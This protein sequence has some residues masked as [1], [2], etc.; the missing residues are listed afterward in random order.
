MTKDTAPKENDEPKFV[1][2]RL[3]IPADVLDGA[4]KI[5][6]EYGVTIPEAVR[7]MLIKTMEDKAPPFD[8]RATLKEVYGDRIPNRETFESFDAIER[9]E[10]FHAKDFEDLMRQLEI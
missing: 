8:I 7:L 5:F 9:G 4:D 10:V 1:Q 3:D 6:Y 2:I